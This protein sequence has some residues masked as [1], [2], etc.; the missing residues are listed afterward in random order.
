[1]GFI[2]RRVL[3][4]AVRRFLSGIFAFYFVVCNIP[5]NDELRS[6]CTKRF[7]DECV[8]LGCIKVSRDLL[9]SSSGFMDASSS[10]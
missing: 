4:T 9:R 10:G 7:I 2:R 5:R 6:R 1:M 3:K 8:P